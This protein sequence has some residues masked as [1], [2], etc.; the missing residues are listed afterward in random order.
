[1]FENSSRIKIEISFTFWD[2]ADFYIWTQNAFIR[3][4]ANV[5]ISYQEYYINDFGLRNPLRNPIEEII[6]QWL[7]ISLTP[8]QVIKQQ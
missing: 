1:M 7:K 8:K 3:R 4:A 6:R 2:S 5:I